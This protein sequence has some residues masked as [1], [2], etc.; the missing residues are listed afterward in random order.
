MR[1]KHPKEV[2][3]ET[4]GNKETYT[5]EEVI[6]VMSEY[7]LQRIGSD[8]DGFDYIPEIETILVQ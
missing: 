4:W 7:L 5:R 8:G 2:L 3:D 6:Y 1:D